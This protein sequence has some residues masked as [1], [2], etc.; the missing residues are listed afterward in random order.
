MATCKGSARSALPQLQLGNR[1]VQARKYCSESALLHFQ[2]RKSRNFK[3]E[4]QHAKYKSV[5]ART[6][7]T[8]R[9]RK[10]SVQSTVPH[11]FAR[12]IKPLHA[13]EK[14]PEVWSAFAHY[15]CTSNVR[16][17]AGVEGMLRTTFAPRSCE[18][19]AG[20]AGVSLSLLLWHLEVAIAQ[21]ELQE[22]TSCG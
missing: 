16:A 4:K 2:A 7:T 5:S 22:S 15:F 14:L 12:S 3:T 1:N 19:P 20:A 13:H 21:P 6:K 10:S 17:S 11:S 18:F 9:Q 8:T